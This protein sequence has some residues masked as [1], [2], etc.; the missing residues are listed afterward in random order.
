LTVT[1]RKTLM[2]WIILFLV[3]I[4]LALIVFVIWLAVVTFVALATV[5]CVVAYG[6]VLAA[7]GA[8][9]R[10]RSKRLE[11]RNPWRLGGSRSASV[12]FR[13]E[14]QARHGKLTTAA[15]KSISSTK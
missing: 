10:E 4:G 2:F 5:A 1:E 3:G 15:E 11:R 7:R 13:R 14:W 6:I 12:V 8:V 9:R